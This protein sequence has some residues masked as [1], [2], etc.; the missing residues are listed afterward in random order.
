[1]TTREN[2]DQLHDVALA[3]TQIGDMR[4]APRDRGGI[5]GQHFAVSV[6]SEFTSFE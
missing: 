5:L 3:A 6:L 4:F 2:I 1:M